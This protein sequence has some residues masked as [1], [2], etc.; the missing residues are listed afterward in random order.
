MLDQMSLLGNVYLLKNVVMKYMR[1]LMVLYI[2]IKKVKKALDLYTILCVY[3]G[4]RNDKKIQ[5]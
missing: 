2:G 1:Q 5:Y 4:I 3:L